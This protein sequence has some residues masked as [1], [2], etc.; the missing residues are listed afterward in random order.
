MNDLSNIINKTVSISI[1]NRGRA[2]QVFSDVKK[3]G[4]L[5]VLKNNEPECVL[6]SP[7]EYVSLMDELNDMR[8]ELLATQRMHNTD[9]SATIPAE[10]VYKNLGIDLN[11]L[12]CFDEVELD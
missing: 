8:L 1:F 10:D 11:D 2:G 9:L 5:V 6:L 4:S 3:R 7:K 12:E